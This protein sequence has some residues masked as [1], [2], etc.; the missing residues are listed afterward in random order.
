MNINRGYNQNNINY[1]NMPPMANSNNMPP[2]TPAVAEQYIGQFMYPEVHDKFYPVVEQILR[3]MEQRNNGEI[4]LSEDMLNQMV[5]DA[6]ARS[7][8]NRNPIRHVYPYDN[9]YGV[10]ETD[11]QEMHEMQD[12]RTSGEAMTETGEDGEAVQTIAGYGRRGG[13]GH[14]RGGYRP[15]G[16]YAGGWRNYDRGAL[17]DIFRILFLQELFGRRRPNWRWR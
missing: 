14:I 2:M 4:Y 6:M 5:E 17:S 13:P 11:M 3:D 16:Y 8:V 1:R 12:M 15:G 7:G 10:N 9:N